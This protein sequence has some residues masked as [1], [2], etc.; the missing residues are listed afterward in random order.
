MGRSTGYQSSASMGM[1]D[2]P[3]IGECILDSERSIFKQSSNACRLFPVHCHWKNTV[4]KS[5]DMASSMSRIIH[6]W[7]SPR[8]LHKLS[9]GWHRTWYVDV[10]H[11]DVVHCIALPQQ[12]SC[13]KVG[14]IKER[15]ESDLRLVPRSDLQKFY[16]DHVHESAWVSAYL[17]N[18]LACQQFSWKVC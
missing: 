9:L 3:V 7:I 18:L 17:T 11:V 16:H 4:I 12:H 8:E 14:I 5:Y 10:V 6:L 13:R 1:V 15:V 2:P